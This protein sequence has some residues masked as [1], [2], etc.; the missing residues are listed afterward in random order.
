MLT[1]KKVFFKSVFEELKWFMNGNTNNKLLKDVGVNI[2]THN[3]A[4]EQLDA[5]GLTDYAVDDCGPIYGYQW[6][7][8]G[9][10]DK[11]GVDQLEYIVNELR[12]NPTSRRAILSAWNPVDL[13]KMCLPPCHMLYNFYVIN[14]RLSVTMTQRSGDIFLGIPFN[15]VSTSLLLI[16]IANIVNMKVGSVTINI[17]DCHLYNEHIAAAKTQLSRRI[18]KMPRIRIK[19]QL[20]ELS[21]AYTLNITDFDIAYKHEPI[22]SARLFSV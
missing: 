14:D 15:I 16:Y 1:S 7:N 8:F 11:S 6:R 17:C 18:H 12:T 4:R 21:D 3:S 5:R 20:R 9:A 10:G 13:P 19:K 2:W 22:I